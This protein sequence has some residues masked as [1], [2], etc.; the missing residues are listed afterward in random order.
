MGED[1]YHF[2]IAN[3]AGACSDCLALTELTSLVRS[4]YEFT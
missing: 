4:W 3:G 1:V 2:A